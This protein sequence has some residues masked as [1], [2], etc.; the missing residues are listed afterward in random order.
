LKK[1]ITPRYSWN[2]A[3]VIYVT[4]YN[5]SGTWLQNGNCISTG[6]LGDTT[7]ND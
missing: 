5:F 4:R 3:K 1:N 2:T 7:R 6:L